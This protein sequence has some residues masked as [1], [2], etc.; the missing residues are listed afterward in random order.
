MARRAWKRLLPAF[1][2]SSARYRTGSPRTCPRC[3]QNLVAN[4][5]L[6]AIRPETPTLRV[7]EHGTASVGSVS[8]PCWLTNSFLI[9]YFVEASMLSAY[10]WPFSLYRGTQ[11]QQPGA[12]RP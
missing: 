1:E 7:V 6:S 5:R 3:L 2:L 11:T 9:K 4:F 8:M 12:T 10:N